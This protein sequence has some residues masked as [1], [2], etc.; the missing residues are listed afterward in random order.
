MLFLCDKCVIKSDSKFSAMENVKE[1]SSISIPLR[2]DFANTEMGKIMHAP[3][4]RYDK[5]KF[6]ALLKKM[7][8]L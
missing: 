7:P 8:D 5:E 4:I 2:L 3:V 1:L 6:N